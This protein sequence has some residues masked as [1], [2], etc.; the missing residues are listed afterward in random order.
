[1]KTM[2]DLRIELAVAKEREYAATTNAI[3]LDNAL[4]TA[5]THRKFETRRR[6]QVEAEIAAMEEEDAVQR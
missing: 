2:I 6:E 1:M 4:R 3:R 5:E